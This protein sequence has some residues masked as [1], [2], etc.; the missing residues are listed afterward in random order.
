MRYGILVKRSDGSQ[1][2][3][4]GS[5]RTVS[6]RIKRYPLTE[7]GVVGVSAQ[8][9]LGDWGPVRHSAPF[10]AVKTPPSMFLAPLAAR[11]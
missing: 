3:L 7:G 1:Q 5:S 6:V 11:R 10:K 4:A 8:G 9:Q 2:R